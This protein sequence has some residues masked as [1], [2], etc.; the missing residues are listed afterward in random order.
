MSKRYRPLTSTETL[1][2]KR[3]AATHGRL[4]KQ[5]LRD[6]WMTASEAGILQALRN[7][8]G[9]SWLVSYQLPK[10]DV[11]LSA[12]QRTAYGVTLECVSCGEFSWD[13]TTVDGVAQCPTCRR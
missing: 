8:H 9:P 6:A 1:T 13:V 7:S 3:Y 5:S 2:V 12:D 10:V 11:E 4:W